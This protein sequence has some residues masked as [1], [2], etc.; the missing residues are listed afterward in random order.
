MRK[1]RSTIIAVAIL[2]VG[3]CIFAYPTVSNW[4]NDMHQ[5]QAIDT[6]VE[7]VENL[8]EAEYERVWNEAKAYNE[9]LANREPSLTLSDAERPAYEAQLNV[10]GNGVMSILEIPPINVRLPIYHGTDNAVLQVAIGHLEGTSLP[11]GGR[12]TH[13]VVSGHRG[14]PSA[15]ILSYLDKVGEG[16]V[17]MLHTLNETLAYEV[18]QIRIVEPQEVDSLS[19][20]EGEDLCTLVTCTPYGVNSHRLLVRGHRVPMADADRVQQ[21]A[22]QISPLLVSLSLG[23]PLVFVVLVVSLFLTRKKPKAADAAHELSSHAADAITPDS[24]AAASS[25][26]ATPA[27]STTPA[28]PADTSSTVAAAPADSTTPANPADTADATTP[29]SPGVS[30]K[31]I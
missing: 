22:F 3:V 20:I 28:N 13:C 14:L 25:P 1:H 5:S 7:A 31:K 8:D 4:W 21:D 18:D 26:D 11:V 30:T 10:A 29:E 17:F 12:S 23:I 27:D 9:R 6:Y 24:A 16:D 2:V 19:I 15:T